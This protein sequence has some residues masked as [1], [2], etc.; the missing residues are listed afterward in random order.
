M[1]AMYWILLDLCLW[2]GRKPGRT[3]SEFGCSILDLFKLN[4][5]NSEI[6]NSNSE[7][8]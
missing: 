6:E 5:H 1:S 7:I 4:Y 8:I 2:W 3:I